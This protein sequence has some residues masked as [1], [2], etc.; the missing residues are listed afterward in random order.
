MKSSIQLLLFF[1]M[2]IG[3]VFMF[4]DPQSLGLFIFYIPCSSDY[5]TDSG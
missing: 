2:E 4:F 5:S 1:L 3:N